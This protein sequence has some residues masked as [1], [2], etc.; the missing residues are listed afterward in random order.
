MQEPAASSFHG[1]CFP[2]LALP[3]RFKGS[4]RVVHFGNSQPVQLP[5][6]IQY[7]Y[8]LRHFSKAVNKN[9]T[10]SDHI[11]TICLER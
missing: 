7:I 4:S 5:Q 3:N 6:Q 1:M 9:I 8:L 11:Q 2:A 10:V